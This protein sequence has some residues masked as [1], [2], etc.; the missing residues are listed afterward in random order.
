MLSMIVTAWNNGAHSRSGSGYGFKVSIDDR[1]AYFK[2][3]W[4]VIVLEIE[5]EMGTFEV[6][7]D[8]DSFWDETCRELASL[9]VGHWLRK[10]G[11][12]PWHLGNPPV[13]TLEPLDE[14]RFQI[15]KVHKSQKPHNKRI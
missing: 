11:L 8:K 7:I 1:D 3:E 14:N 10:N 12:A 6:D 4:K 5:E 9:E 13:F 2:R 15:R